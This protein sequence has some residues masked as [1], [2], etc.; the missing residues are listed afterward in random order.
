MPDLQHLSCPRDGW[1]EAELGDANLG[2]FRLKRRVVDLAQALGA[3][4]SLSIQQACGSWR[5]AKAAY[6]FFDGGAE[7]SAAIR[8]AHTDATKARAG[9]C[10]VVLAVQ[11]TTSLDFTHHPDT[12]GLGYLE[13][14]KRQGLVVHS[15]LAVTLDGV[16][17]GL[18]AQ[19]VWARDT[20]QRGIRHHRRERAIQSKESFKWLQAVAESRQGLTDG[21]ILLHVGDR[22]SDVYDLFLAAQGQPDTAL[23]VRA[24]RDRRIAED[25]ARLWAYMRGLPEQ[26]RRLVTLPR[27][28]SH[29]GREAR[30]GIRWAPVTIRPPKYR[31]HEPLAPLK[32]HA[33]LVEEQPE[34][35]D[36]KPICWLLL[37]TLP[38]EE[39]EF[40]WQLVTWYG[41]RWRIE[42]YH[43]ILKSGCRIEERQLGTAERLDC[44]LAL[45]SVIASRLLMLTYLARTAP[46]EPG[47]SLLNPDEWRVLWAKQH[48]GKPAPRHPTL[49]QVVREIA[50]LGG[51]LGRR[52]DGEPGAKS[53][54]RGLQ[55]LNDLLLGYEMAL[56]FHRLRGNE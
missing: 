46:N 33:V 43:Y 2:D 35:S 48:R 44:C 8:Q 7:S 38:V 1:L 53:L 56:S 34:E 13:T 47:A 28:Q 27:S 21:T 51:F 18:L 16:P 40:A 4:P 45:Y 20:D 30:L 9:Q 23:L 42:R 29:T 11:D 25:E 24:T 26:A 3:Q 52:G 17:L 12:S 32:L 14:R 54:W 55:R 37:T 6:R 15:T 19:Q 49:R 10:Q 5:T 31:S 22:E 39:A 41:Y 50:C 36:A